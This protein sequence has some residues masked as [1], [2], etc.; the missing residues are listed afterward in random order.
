MTMRV[1]RVIMV[2]IVRHANNPTKQ[3]VIVIV[4]R[5]QENREDLEKKLQ[6]ILNK[7]RSST[8]PG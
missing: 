1:I 4:S 3:S 6:R 8:T 7:M 5:V 2:T